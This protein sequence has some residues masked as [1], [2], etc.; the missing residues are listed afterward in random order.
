MSTT[1]T[2]LTCAPAHA[3]LSP[4]IPAQPFYNYFTSD[5]SLDLKPI[6]L[7]KAGSETDELGLSEST[8]YFDPQRPDSPAG[9]H[10]YHVSQDSYEPAEFGSFLGSD[11]DGGAALQILHNRPPSTELVALQSFEDTHFPFSMALESSSTLYSPNYYE[12]L[13]ICTD[14]NSHGSA[15]VTSSPIVP[16]VEEMG[17]S[18]ELPLRSDAH[19]TFQLS[20]INT[21]I[22]HLMSI[23]QDVRFQILATEGSPGVLTLLAHIFNLSDFISFNLHEIGL[24]EDGILDHSTLLQFWR[25]YNEC[26]L[27]VIDKMELFISNPSSG[28]IIRSRLYDISE[29]LVVLGDKL[30]TFGLVDYEIGLWEERIVNSKQCVIWPCCSVD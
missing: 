27:L 2:I 19:D 22:G 6:I 4:R 7:A 10:D 18:Q 20:S 12:I 11:H 3:A 8:A 24:A 5:V 21:D 16:T 29:H 9:H 30:H 13:S 17:N 1:L 14:V 26:W 28:L 23:F 15:A 25:I